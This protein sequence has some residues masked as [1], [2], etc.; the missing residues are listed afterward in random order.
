MKRS[1]MKIAVVAAFTTIVTIGHGT[2]SSG[3][4]AGDITGKPDSKF[5][6]VQVGTITYSYRDLSDQSLT[7]ILDYAVKSGINSVEL[8]GGAVEKYAGI[9]QGDAETIRQWRTTVSMDKFKEI[10]KMFK[11]KGVKIHILKLGEP[12]WSDEE[13]DY[14]FKACKAVGAKGITTEVSEN[15]AKRLS[16]FAD[17]HKLYVIF[18]NHGQPGNPD[19]S[20]DRILQ[21]G[22][23][24]MLNFDV[25]HYFGATGKHPNELII[26]LHDRIFSIHV[27]DKTAKT[28][29]DPDKNRPFGQ[30][31]TPLSDIF[32][33]IKKE[34]WPIYCD[35]ELEYSIPKNS[36]PVSEVVK[37][38]EYCKQILQ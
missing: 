23:R 4:G 21:H 24:L 16:P 7:A 37:C 20:F 28:A 25:G 2:V 30:G 29:S 14:A 9:P 18:H 19:F 27:K 11:E 10:R 38:V 34:K 26:R 1:F 15:A 5:N 17:K 3:A 35:I 31:D 8:M 12:S 32:Q 33:L 36:D 13:I 6:G 22:K